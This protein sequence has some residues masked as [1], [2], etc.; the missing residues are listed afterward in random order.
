MRL[1]TLVKG[2][3]MCMVNLN[4]FTVRDFCERLFEGYLEYRFVRDTFLCFHVEGDGI[5]NERMIGPVLSC[6]FN[7]FVQ[8]PF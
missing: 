7:S 6:P 4:V 2:T 1:S 3:K 8:N 5:M